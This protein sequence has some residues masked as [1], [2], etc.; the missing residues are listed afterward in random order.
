MSPLVLKSPVELA[1]MDEANALVQRILDELEQRIRP[2]MTTMEI[3]AFAEREIRGAGAIPAFKGYPHRGDGHDFPGTVCSSVNAEVVHGIPSPHVVLREGDTVSIDLGVRLRGFYGDGARTYP[4]GRITPADQRLLDVT[5]ASLELGVQQAR[6]GNRVSDIGHAIQ[7]H[8]EA[9]GYSVVREFVGHGIGSA[10]HEEPQVPNFGEPGRRERLVPGLVLAIEP[11]VNAG[12]PDVVLSA[13]DGW[14]ARTRDGSRSAHF[15][16][17]VAITEEGPWVLGRP[18]SAGT[19]RP[20]AGPG[21]EPGTAPD[22][23]G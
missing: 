19:A 9:H 21:R 12:G 20:G 16:V 13:E 15:E 5:Q 22:P 7:S 11:M 4:V 8:V 2:G 17:S 14:T 3:D 6:P 10:L 1:I 23:T 18:R